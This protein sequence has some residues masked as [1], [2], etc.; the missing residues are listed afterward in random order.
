MEKVYD[1]PGQA[2]KL[3]KFC[4]VVSSATTILTNEDTAGTTTVVVTDTD[5]TVAPV[6]TVV[7]QGSQGSAVCGAGAGATPMFTYACTYTPFANRNGADTFSVMA[8]DGM[9]NSPASLPV[10]V[11][12]TP[13]N[14][15]PTAVTG[16]R[17]MA[18]NSPAGTVPITVT[19]VDIATNGDSFTYAIATL[20]ANGT[21]V[22]VANAVQYT[23]NLNFSGTDTFTV[24]ATDA[25]GLA[26]TGTVMVTVSS[27]NNPPSIVTAPA[28]TTLEDNP[29]VT[30]V[31]ATDPD[32]L[33]PTLSISTQGAKGSAVCGA[34]A[35]VN[36]ITWNY[37]C[38][39]T[40]GLNRN[41]VDSFSVTASDGLATSV[42]SAVG[43][44]I[45]PV[46][47]APS[48]VSGSLT[49]A[50][51][52]GT[53]NVTMSVT[54][55]DIATNGDTHTFTIAT[56]PA[57]GTAAVVANVVQ[58]TP[59]LNF[60]GTDSFTVMAT[61][62][63]G[64]ANTGT[65]TVTVT[66]VN[67]APVITAAPA[68]ST[69]EDTAGATIVAVT[70][71][72][73]GMAPVVSVI[74]A[75]AKGG[76]TC[77]TAAVV[78]AT[79]WT[80][81]CPFTPTANL[82]GADS[83]IVQANDGLAQV[84]SIVSVSIT[85]V[86]D[87]PSAVS[88]SLTMAENSGIGN[89]AMSVTD[90][91][92]ATNGDTHTFTIAIGPAN[93]LAAV[94][95][96]VVQYTPN[97]NFNGTD[98]FTVTATDAGGLARTGI[99]TV[100]VTPVNT[101]PVITS[102]TAITT[103]EDTA[104]TTT[105]AVTD[106]DGPTPTLAVTTPGAKGVVACGTA[107][108][109]TATSWTFTCTYTPTANLNGTDTFS[110]QANDGALTSTA[111]AVG[112]TI[113]AVNDTPVLGG[114]ASPTAFNSGVLTTISGVTVT[115]PD[116]ATNADAITW[117]AAGLP[118]GF[119]INPVTGVISGTGDGL[120]LTSPEG[121]TVTVTATDLALA[122][123]T[124]NVTLSITDV[125]PPAAVTLPVQTAWTATS[126]TM[127]WADPATAD[128]TQMRLCVAGGVSDPV[129]GAGYTFVATVAKGVQTYTHAGLVNPSVNNYLL[130]AQDEAPNAA[131]A[132][133]L[134][135][136]HTSNIWTWKGGPSTI[137]GVGVY[138][139]KG[140]AAVGNQPGSRWGSATWRDSAGN[141]WLFGGFGLGSA[142]TPLGDLNDLWMYNPTTGLWTWVAGSSTASAWGMAG[143]K[144]S[145]GVYG[146]KGTAAA[147]NTPPPLDSATYW[148]D[149][150][151]NFW[152]FGGMDNALNDYHDMWK[153]S[154]ATGM[155][156]WMHGDGVVNGTAGVYGTIGTAAA[157]NI[158]AA[159]DSAVGWADTAGNLWLFGGADSI[160]NWYSDL[161]KYNTTTNQWTCVK[162]PG[163]LANNPNVKGTYGALG[164]AAAANIP[165]G[166]LGSA[167]WTDTAGN[168]WLFGG[169]GYDSGTATIWNN[170]NDLWKFDPATGMWTWMAGSSSA[171][172]WATIGTKDPMGMYGTKGTPAAGNTPPPLASAKTWVDATGNL[173]LFGGL[174]NA[175]NDYH[176]MW[177]FDVTLGQWV[178]VNGDGLVGNAGVYGTLNTHATTNLPGPRDLTAGWVDNQG[179][180]WLFGGFGNGS[181]ITTG[182]LNDLWIYYP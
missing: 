45:T 114:T 144:D 148:T 98:T 11:S 96:N 152:L 86:N 94:V 117:S 63:G 67:D 154:V 153:F 104:G 4:P 175:A 156:T 136:T 52:S 66:A 171:S 164:T 121:Y 97:W 99:V 141:F 93:G 31:Q 76:V 27:T 101:A 62:A 176:D 122:A 124:M 65:V 6:L 59:N 182:R 116:I 28:L 35:M 125:T 41:G 103:L 68:I 75:P 107:T 163:N 2:D 40:P 30:T 172:T 73:G 1:G 87:A 20:P 77:G 82:N 169:L 131:T 134:V 145:M 129:C 83:F 24:T 70:D 36:P 147:A 137:N 58:Y 90:P 118:A 170:L 64:L 26:V 106:A 51:D 142:A 177:K 13:V 12:I 50:E 139:T 23:P 126:I 100:T 119:T 80:Y 165:G 159:L 157:T 167:A 132:T 151:G 91:D 92:I 110:V 44:T 38:T 140:V 56:L 10:G 105:V 123:A 135:N 15:A 33:P 81:S 19:D 42:A 72:D 17:T 127:T 22:V 3:C 7:G 49:M 120:G 160:L 166:R 102:V 29:G 39:Y 18:V 54:D 180:F 8:N 108:V 79:S 57:N 48:A 173:W 78:S 149:S 14:D 43:V 111:T 112:V 53:G 88:G 46:N 25:G 9:Y 5:A 84:T 161:W 55:V 95:T 89:V 113:T 174:D 155:W 158:P 21:A 143:T 34:P 181:T 138:G 168:M 60:N 146:T 74:T 162:A 16:F 69:F 61:D 128:Y 47:D 32:G 130:V 133:A 109:V 150:S 85:P 115:D 71:V 178:W 179:Q 37:V